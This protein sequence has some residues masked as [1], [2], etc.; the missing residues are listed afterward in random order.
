M[1]LKEMKIKTFSLIEEYYPDKKDLAEE[2]ALL[3]QY[4]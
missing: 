2:M 1:T 4:N 3:I